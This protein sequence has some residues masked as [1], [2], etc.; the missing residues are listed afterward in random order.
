MRTL[1]RTLANSASNTTLMASMTKTGLMPVVRRR[2][3]CVSPESP[4][5]RRRG[6]PNWGPA[7]LMRP[8]GPL[9]ACRWYFSRYADARASATAI[10]A[11]PC[12][13]G[14]MS[15]SVPDLLIVRS[16]RLAV[17]AT[18]PSLA[19]FATSYLA[20]GAGRT[21][22]RTCRCFPCAGRTGPEVRTPTC[23]PRRIA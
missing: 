18:V 8:A 17:K 10:I 5:Q 1:H 13:G 16:R 19:V 22:R 3:K 12:P 20:P 23:M 7:Q 15:T 6:R 21:E 2:N 14:V 4:G 11:A 9:P